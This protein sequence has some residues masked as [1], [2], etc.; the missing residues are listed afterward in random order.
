M[1]V[2]DL[3]SVPARSKRSAK[4][5]NS[6]NRRSRPT[7]ADL[8]TGTVDPFY[9]TVVPL[10]YDTMGVLSPW[11]SL[12]D[13]EVVAMWNLVFGGTNPL[14]PGNTKDHMFIIIKSLV[15]YGISLLEQH[16][17]DHHR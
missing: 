5:S 1:K 15:C 17:H 7:N 6:D 13:E 14:T 12:P 11:D 9:S 2:E 8:P 10:I 3:H 4:G 16:S